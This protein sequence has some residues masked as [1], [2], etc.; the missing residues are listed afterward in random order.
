[1]YYRYLT[2]GSGAGLPGL[3]ERYRATLLSPT[4]SSPVAHFASA[5]FDSDGAA[6]QNVAAHATKL[7]LSYPSTQG[8]RISVGS[9]VTATA[10]TEG[11]MDVLGWREGRWLVV[12]GEPRSMPL[13]SAKLVAEY[14]HQHFMPVPEPQGT[15][16]GMIVVDVE[17]DGPHTEV[18]WQE[19]RWVYS[20]G[21]D[22]KAANPI[23]TGLTMALSMRQFGGQAGK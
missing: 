4:P 10:Q 22:P 19:G 20:T 18:A 15:A 13:Q 9:D 7:G 21:T 17:S 1:M 3:I 6:G 5:V 14:L 16:D 23:D 2:Q 12:V 11:R 8:A